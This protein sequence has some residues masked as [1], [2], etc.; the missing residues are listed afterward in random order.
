[1]ATG[2]EMALHFRELDER[3]YTIL[4]D[5]L[6][7]Q[8]VDEAVAAARQ[9]YATNDAPGADVTFTVY[10]SNHGDAVVEVSRGGPFKNAGFYKVALVEA[11]PDPG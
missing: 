3:G 6:S 1:M 7:P 2:A 11:G 9:D 10:R 4:E 8:Q 5:L